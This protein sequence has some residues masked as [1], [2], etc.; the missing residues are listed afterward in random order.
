MKYFTLTFLAT[1]IVATNVELQHVGHD[2]KLTSSIL[3]SF[4][5]ATVPDIP[6]LDSSTITSVMTE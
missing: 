4:L 2:H 3:E 1:T 6:D 5:E